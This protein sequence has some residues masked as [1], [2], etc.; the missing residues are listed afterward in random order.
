MLFGR[1]HEEIEYL[2]KRNIP[3]EI[4]PGITA[5]LGASAELQISLTRRGLARSV[6]FATTRAADDEKPSD[7]VR[8]VASADTAVLY[9]ASRDAQRVR[10]ALLAAGMRADTPVAIAENVSLNATMRAGV[11]CDLPHLAERCAGPALLMIGEVFG[12]ISTETVDIPVE[13]R[14]YTAS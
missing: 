13:S 5:A 10:D 12:R 9:M 2:K 14:R 3:V 8:A 11:L 7:W 1:A 4:V 6:A